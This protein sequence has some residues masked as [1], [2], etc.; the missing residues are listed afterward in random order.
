LSKI[1]E[2]IIIFWSSYYKLANKIWRKLNGIEK[3][4][5]VSSIWGKFYT[6]RT[7]YWIIELLLL[8]M[9]VFFSPHHYRSL[10]SVSTLMKWIIFF[11]QKPNLVFNFEIYKIF[12]ALLWYCHMS[13]EIIQSVI[14]DILQWFSTCQL[15]ILTKKIVSLFWGFI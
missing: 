10:G 7:N 11:F 6:F 2:L 3:Y 12:H 4:V 1:L 5:W 9:S 8:L 14:D 13:S 15:H